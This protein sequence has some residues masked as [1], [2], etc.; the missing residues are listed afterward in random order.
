MSSEIDSTD[1]IGGVGAV[2]D[3]WRARGADRV[4]ATRFRFIEALARRAQ[5]YDGDVRRVLDARLVAL[6]AD[7]ARE[8]E[9]AATQATPTTKATDTSSTS[10]PGSALAELAGI[11]V[12]SRTTTAMRDGASPDAG[13]LPG[14]R[15][16]RSPE[17]PVLDYFRETWSKFSAEKQLRQSLEKVPENAGPLNTS[18]LVHRS[19][20][21]MREVSPGYLQHFLSYIE[22]LSWIEQMSA[23]V[24]AAVATAA[25]APRVNAGKKPPR[26]KA[27]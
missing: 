25:P 17:L 13:A 10:R 9:R 12:A 15:L 26:G 21:L 19:L 24:P 3:E 2:L 1:G 14:H 7:Y 22:A 6:I 16:D 23:P 8:L 4:N 27:R 20:S 18:H 5:R 11:L